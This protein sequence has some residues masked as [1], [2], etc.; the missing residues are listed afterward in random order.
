MTNA[1]IAPHR[2]LILAGFMGTGKTTVGRLCARR[3]GLDFVDADE[4]ISRREGM[5]I[6]AIFATYGEGYF[7]QRERA[8]VAELADRRGCVIATG[9]GM[10]VDDDN[11][12]A[13]LSSGVGVCLTATPEVILKRVGGEAAAAERPMLRGG[14]VAAR[15]A[16]LLRE[17]APKYAQMHYC[18]D[19]SRRVPDEVAALVCEI[20]RREHARIAVDIPAAGARYDI[21]LGDDVLDEL[22]FMLAGRGWTPPFAVVSDEV[23]APRYGERALRALDRAGLHGF[24]HAMPA[25]EAHKTLAS[26]EAMYRA[27]SAH[28]MER[29]SAVIALGGGVVGDTA[30]FAAATFL[31][32][33]PLVQVPTSLL[34][35]ADS[36]IGGKVGVDTDFGKNLVG[37][38]KQPD[39]VV[40]DLSTLASL[41]D[42]ER[43]C[44]LAEIIKAALLSGG[45]AYVRLRDAAARRTLSDERSP[46]LFAALMD[47][48]LLKRAIVQEDPFERGRRAL[49]NLGHTFGHGIEAWSG[50]RLKHGEAVSLGMVCAI[51]LSRAMGFCDGEL[52]QEVIGLLRNVGLPTTLDDVRSALEGVTFTPDAVWSYMMSD[53]KKR[54]GKLR[55]VL[56][57]APGDAFVCDDVDE[58]LARQ[59]LG[60]LAHVDD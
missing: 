59:T 14:D 39:L 42:R 24:L 53:K 36:S 51:R 20:Y 44:G 60:Q 11:R 5:P 43:R 37:A 34:A 25:G 40:A 58:H 19:T 49:L 47:A 31:R 54:A 13:L 46:A 3:L 52:A 10:I 48:I 28:G 35:M 16:L 23:V 38:F 30:G 6:P 41:P 50:F 2:N 57:R 17:R 45:Q 55:F 7:R 15:I 9:G 29:A 32:G 12:T 8:L 33:V 22:G 18:V 4:E 56:L 27:F 1:I 21:V 26:V